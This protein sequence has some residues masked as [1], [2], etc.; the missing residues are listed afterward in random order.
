MI[1]RLTLVT[2]VATLVAGGC[3]SRQQELENVAKDWCLTIRASQVMPVYPL[4]EDLQ[5]GD[6]FLVGVPID[7][8]QQQ[9]TDKGF[10]PLD[11][12]F[13]RVQPSGYAAFY[14][15]SFPQA[16]GQMPLHF[17]AGSN[18]SKTPPH[19]WHLAPASAFPTYSF[20]VKQG[21][22]FNLALPIQGVP[23]G[24][25]LLGTAEA[26][27]TVVISEAHTYGIDMGSLMGDLERALDQ[28][29]GSGVTY[30]QL[31]ARFHDPGEPASAG[32]AART[33]HPVYLRIVSRVYVAGAMD[34]AVQN[35]A[36]ESGGLSA[37]SFKPVDLLDA[38]A[39]DAKDLEERRKVYE[40]GRELIAKKLGEA[41]AGAA[42]GGALQLQSASARSVTLKETFARPLV[43]GYLALD[44]RIESGGRLS[45]AMPTLQVL[46]GHEPPGPV[47]FTALQDDANRCLKQLD[48]WVAA[49]P[50]DAPYVEFLRALGGSFAADTY[51]VALGEAA[52]ASPAKRAQAFRFV[53]GGL[54]DLHQLSPGPRPWEQRVVEAART[55]TPPN[56]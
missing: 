10:L 3:T 53:L 29:A 34:V 47:V 30:R 19:R 33:G 40:T 26:T 44:C 46:A 49:G 42:P 22:G 41:L 23:V 11:Q 56:H 51:Q 17:M 43:I 6:C 55:V 48:A 7:E 37:G 39:G 21:G 27:G 54:L 9:W 32:H 36:S 50:N 38:K 15:H 4:R 25:S 1:R 5:P 8:Q 35:A 13:L 31:L 16:D 18:D 2:A 28:P 12:Q 24:L 14:A 52:T 20:H 45:P